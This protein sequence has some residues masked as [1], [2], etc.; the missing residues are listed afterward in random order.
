MRL[1]DAIGMVVVEDVGEVY[2]GG[3][4]GRVVVEFWGWGEVELVDVGEA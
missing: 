3:L 2:G 4:E 1:E